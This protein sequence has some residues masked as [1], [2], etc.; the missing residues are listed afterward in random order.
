MPEGAQSGDAG[1]G[2]VT[3]AIR[4]LTRCG[5]GPEAW[6]PEPLQVADSVAVALEGAL[7][8]GFI[9]PFER[10]AAGIAGRRVIDVMSVAVVP[11]VGLIGVVALVA[12]ASIAP[13]QH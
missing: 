12:V 1:T 4:F 2:R 5:F 6:I 11:L 10:L 3:R 7:L 13:H 8:A 9:A